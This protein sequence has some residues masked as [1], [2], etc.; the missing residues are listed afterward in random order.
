MKYRGR[1]AE[2]LG[3]PRAALEKLYSGNAR[4]I[5]PGLDKIIRN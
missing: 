2:C 3:L 4:W 5:I 1:E